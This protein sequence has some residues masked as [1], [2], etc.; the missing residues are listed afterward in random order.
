M[1]IRPISLLWILLM[2]SLSA[3][4]GHTQDSNGDSAPCFIEMS[5]SASADAGDITLHYS[6]E[7]NLGLA[8]ISCTSTESGYV[9]QYEGGRQG[10]ITLQCCTGSS[11]QI[12]WMRG[13]T[14]CH[15]TISTPC[16]TGIDSD[17]DGRCDEEDCWSDDPSNSYGPGDSC[18]DGDPTTGGDQYDENCTC[19]G[20]PGEGCL[21]DYDGDGICDED[22]CWPQDANLTYS[23]G[24]YCNDGNASTYNDSY[25]ANCECEGEPLPC[26][27]IW[28]DDGCPLTVDV[29]NDDCTVSNITPDPDDG[30]PLTFDYFDAVNCVIVNELPNVDDGCAGTRDYFNPLTCE[31]VHEL[32]PCNDGDFK[33]V[34]DKYTDSCEC[35]GCDPCQLTGEKW[36]LLCELLNR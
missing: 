19:I 4:Y 13:L 9:G 2:W 21:T 25:N 15:R 26:G 7:Q 3:Q 24:D 17:G 8:T 12:S 10:S 27:D 33:T 6:L 29:I 34:G 18:D 20:V 32:L 35:Q 22:D 16:C 28:P 11:L 36:I 30:C 1:V 14:P 23:V 5:T 31:I